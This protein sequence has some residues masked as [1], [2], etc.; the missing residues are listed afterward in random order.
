M[1]PAQAGALCHMG[2]YSVWLL[3]D[4]R[5]TPAYQLP[6][7]D[8]CLSGPEDL[9]A[10][11]KMTSCPSPI[12]QHNCGSLHEPP[13]RTQVTSPSHDDSTSPALGTERIPLITSGS[14]AGKI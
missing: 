8:G 2:Q 10:S 4:P 5:A 1:L 7:N 6:R 3:D 9:P 12:G 14:C 11:L 13:R